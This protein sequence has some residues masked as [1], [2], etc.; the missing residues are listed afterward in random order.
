MEDY[1]GTVTTKPN[2]TL[3][4]IITT[5]IVMPDI[6]EFI[7][8]LNYIFGNNLTRQEKAPYVVMT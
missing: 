7:T 6:V 5:H 8:K 1:R 4:C 2:I 3:Q